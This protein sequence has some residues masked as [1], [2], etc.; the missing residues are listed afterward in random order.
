V[1]VGAGGTI[2]TSTDGLTWKPRT[3]DVSPFL[4]DVTFTGTSFWA[5]GWNGAILESGPFAK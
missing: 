3:L 1:V 4:K 2:L 5:V